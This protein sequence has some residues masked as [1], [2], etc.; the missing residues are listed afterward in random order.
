[1]NDRGNGN[2]VSNALGTSAADR[3]GLRRRPAMR[4]T[5]VMGCAT[6]LLT[7][8]GSKVAGPSD[9]LSLRPLAGDP[10]FRETVSLSPLP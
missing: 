10:R 8:V 4:P 7:A 6:G 5:A 1:M 3:M 2:G 9:V